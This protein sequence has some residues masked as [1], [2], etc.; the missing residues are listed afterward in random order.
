MKNERHEHPIDDPRTTA[1]VLDELSAAERAQLELELA[2]RPE[3][4]DEVHSIAAFAERLR[5]GFAGSKEPGL[6][7]ERRAEILRATQAPVSRPRPR[8]VRRI[9]VAA[10]V[11]ALTGAAGVLA[12]RALESRG[13]AA[14]SREE[15]TTVGPRRSVSPP[16]AR[17]RGCEHAAVAADSAGRCSSA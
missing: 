17:R 1:Y 8:L 14:V 7:A 2:S 5:S 16:V 12:L 4:A 9:A 6:D 13:R 15:A 3:L 10:G 11:I